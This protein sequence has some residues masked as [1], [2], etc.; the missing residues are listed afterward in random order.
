MTVSCS[1]Q[2]LAR[3]CNMNFYLSS[4]CVG[5]V[6]S[7]MYIRY[8]RKERREDEATTMKVGKAGAEKD[9]HISEDSFFLSVLY[10]TN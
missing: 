1:G 10:Q 5:A 4:M 7:K 8:S 9:G 6:K 3:L 2:K